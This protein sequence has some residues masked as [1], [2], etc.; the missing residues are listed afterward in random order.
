M[1]ITLNSKDTK[2][3]KLAKNLIKIGEKLDINVDIFEKQL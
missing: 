3:R 1:D 2:I